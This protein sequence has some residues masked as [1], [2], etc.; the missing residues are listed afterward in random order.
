MLRHKYIAVGASAAGETLVNALSGLGEK[1]RV[2]KSLQFIPNSVTSAGYPLRETRVRAY[3]NQDQ[4]VDAA[5]TNFAFSVYSSYTGTD[6]ASTYEMD[7]PLKQGDGFKV[8]LYNTLYAPAGNLQIVY[9]E[10]D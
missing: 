10:K 8:G 3:K 2:I 5:L 1:D 9:E 6:L 7:L 4:I